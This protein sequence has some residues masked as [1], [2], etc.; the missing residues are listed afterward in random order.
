MYIYIY[1]EKKSCISGIFLE[2]RR[3]EVGNSNA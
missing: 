2:I 1:I 3:N